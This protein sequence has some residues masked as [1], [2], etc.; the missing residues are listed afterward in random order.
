MPWSQPEPTGKRAK[1]TS[2]IRAEYE[3]IPHAPRIHPA[4]MSH[5]CRIEGACSPLATRGGRA[6]AAGAEAEESDSFAGGRTWG[7][8]IFSG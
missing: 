3:R 1:N 5:I 7:C 8:A 2:R 4:C 6:G